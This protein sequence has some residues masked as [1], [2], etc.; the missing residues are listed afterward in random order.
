R[1][2]DGRRLPLL[3]QHCLDGAVRHDLRPHGHQGRR[4]GGHQEYRPQ[5]RRRHEKGPHGPG[6]CP[7]WPARRRRR[8]GRRWPCLLRRQLRRRARDARH[9]DQARQPQE[10]QGLLVV[11]RQRL[12]DHR[13][14]H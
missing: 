14:R 12:L 9:H 10:R 8:C 1:G 7:D 13:R 11:V 2:A 6:R 5:A 4:Q 3:V